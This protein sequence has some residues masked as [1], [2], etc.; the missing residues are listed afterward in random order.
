MMTRTEKEKFTAEIAERLLNELRQAINRAIARLSWDDITEGPSIDALITL[1]NE[2]E[3][4]LEV[5]DD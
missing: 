1:R 5:E 4:I 2:I 3:E